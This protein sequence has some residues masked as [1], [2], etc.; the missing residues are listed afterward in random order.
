MR[1]FKLYKIDIE[2]TRKCQLNCYH[3]LR[4]DSQQID[5]DNKIIDTFFS[6]CEIIHVIEITGGEPLS[7]VSGIRYLLDVLKKYNVVVKQLFIT[8]NGVAFSDEI[9]NLMKDFYDYIFSV[10]SIDDYKQRNIFHLYISK[11]KYHVGSNPKEA[12]KFYKKFFMGMPYIV[13][14]Y[15]KGGETPIKVGKA[16]RLAEAVEWIPGMATKIEYLCAER[17]ETACMNYTPKR[18]FIDHD[19]Q[20]FIFCPL[21]LSAKGD[22]L[23]ALPMAPVEYR[24]IDAKNSYKICNVLSDNIFESILEYNDSKERPFCSAFAIALAKSV[25]KDKN[26]NMT[27]NLALRPLAYTYE[28]E[29]NGG[30]NTYNSWIRYSN[31]Y[32]I[33]AFGNS[34][35]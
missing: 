31:K 12:L 20:I 15:H 26:A 1:K 4:G 19:N 18:D 9:A 7:N 10:N 34:T 5:M 33:D 21:Y 3:C 14:E 25:D 17:R 35:G 2:I 29:L 16:K 6:Q 27:K 11:D 30:E 24:V 32:H 8:T 23:K 28:G 13:I 22:L